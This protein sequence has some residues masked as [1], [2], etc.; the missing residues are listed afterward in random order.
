MRYAA[1]DGTESETVWNS[2]DGV[3]PFVITLRSGK[4]ATHADWQGDLRMPETWAPPPGM[5]YFADMTPDRARVHAERA[6][7]RWLADPQ[8]G[9]M[10]LDRYADRDAAVLETAR[11]YLE[12]PGAPDL[13]DPAEDGR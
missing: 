4:T 11:S 6:V 9:P 7:A 13:I 2:R 3:T 5:R 1:D 10:L 8:M 12:Q